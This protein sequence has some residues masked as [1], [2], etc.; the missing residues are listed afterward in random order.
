MLLCPLN[1]LGAMSILYKPLYRPLFFS[2]V[3]D[4]ILFDLIKVIALAH[5][6]IISTVDKLG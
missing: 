1:F 6:A 2:N 3:L 5:L 4:L